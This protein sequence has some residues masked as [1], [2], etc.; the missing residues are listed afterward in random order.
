VWLLDAIAQAEA[1]T[2]ADQLSIAVLHQ[3]GDWDDHVLVV[4]R[5]GVFVD[6]MGVARKLEG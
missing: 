6:C 1:S 4:L 5:L 2:T 3:V